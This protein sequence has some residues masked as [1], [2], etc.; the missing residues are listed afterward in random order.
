MHHTG[1]MSHFLTTE[2]SKEKRSQLR[3]KIKME[4]CK[5]RKEC[6]KAFWKFA[7]RIL[8]EEDGENTL[9]TFGADVAEQFFKT[10]Y[11]SS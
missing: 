11:H 1:I 4:A 6:A 2:Y 8:D 5:A 7:T 9:P 10:V 3:F